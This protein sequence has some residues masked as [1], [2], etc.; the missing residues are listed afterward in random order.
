[1]LLNLSD[2]L[3]T[4]GKVEQKEAEIEMSCFKSKMG[5]C[6]IT[7][8]SSAVF[9]LTNMGQGK[10]ILNGEASLSFQAICDRCLEDVEVP[11][12]LRFER[13]FVAPDHEEA[14][15]I[16]TS[17]FMEGYQLDVEML[18]Y[19]EILENWPVKILCKEDCKGVCPVCGKNLNQGECGCDRFVPDPRMAVIKDIFERNKEV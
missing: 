19:H 17:A 18:M 11:M 7:K 16:D 13:I 14:E 15:E 6:Q 12:E 2:V 10:A 3:T 5:D 8:K 9:T 1:M 4:E